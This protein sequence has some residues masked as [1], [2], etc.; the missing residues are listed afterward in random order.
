MGYSCRLGEET[1]AWEWN[2]EKGPDNIFCFISFCLL[3]LLLL[4]LTAMTSA[5]IFF[6]CKNLTLLCPQGRRLHL[7]TVQI[8]D[9]LL[10]GDC[11]FLV[12]INLISTLDQHLLLSV[13][14]SAFWS[15]NTYISSRAPSGVVKRKPID[16]A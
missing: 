16:R 3:V 7:T 1:R 14:N 9:A 13:G 12:N 11:S 10:P 15:V 4:F 5:P 8:I 6:H 2:A